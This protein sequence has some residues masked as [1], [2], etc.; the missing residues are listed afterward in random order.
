MTHQAFVD[1][2]TDL[3]RSIDRVAEDLAPDRPSLAAALRK[4][5]AYLPRPE[6]LTVGPPPTSGEQ[7]C[8]A[9]SPLMYQALDEGVLDAREFDALMV[10]RARAARV[11]GARRP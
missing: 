1:L 11:L 6:E 3:H 5:A 7:A 10:R 9:L 2:L 8:A 4:R